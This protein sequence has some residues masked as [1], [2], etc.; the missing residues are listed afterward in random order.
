MNLKV[1][2][3]KLSAGRPVAI[4]HKKLADKIGIH[5]D[6]RI[7][8]RKNSKKIVAVVDIA[9]GIFEKEDIAIS[10]EVS[11]KL[12]LKENNIV[13]IEI[14]PRPES[15]SIITKKLKC[16]RLTEPEIREVIEDIVKNALTESEIAYFVSAINNCGMSMKEIVEMTKAIVETGKRLNLRKK[17]IVDKHGIGGIPGK[18]TPIIVSISAAAGLIM[19]KTS[20]RAITTPAGTADALETICKVDFTI[21]EIKKI[22]K[23][24]GACMVWG[25]S[26]GLAPADDKIIQV[27]RLLNLDPEAQLLASIMAKKLAAGSK[28]ILIEI[29]YGKYA[30]IKK[31]DALRLKKKFNILG[32]SF[33]VKIK[34]L[35][36]RTEQ[37]L[38]N[39]IGAALEIKDVISVLKRE[40]SCFL[41]EKR[42]LLLS[43]QI[44]EMAGKVKKGEG[45]KTAL[46]I[47]NSGKAFK[48]FLQI[49]KAQKGNLN[50]IKE[51]RLKHVIHAKSSN[52]IF[53]IDVKKINSLARILGCPAD[54]FSGIYLWKHAGERVTKGEKILTLYSESETELKEGIKFYRKNNPIIFSR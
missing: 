32:K 2:F 16:K 39:G 49:I 3:L 38:G 7:L 20:S 4:L 45:M 22:I 1:K 17:V 25:G 34:C 43:S 15:I 5:V 19:P 33:N 42:A 52:K 12:G 10:T 48:K 46:E 8:I 41:L 13:Q 6:D 14:A 21:P 27:E 53:E 9:T 11:E 35:A 31:K 28:Y 23:K 36:L 26:L 54:K 44:L 29:P 30:K 37:P 24:T 18:T 51:A 40:N 47:L 50:H